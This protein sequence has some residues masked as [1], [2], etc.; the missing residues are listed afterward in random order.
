MP[1]EIDFCFGISDHDYCSQKLARRAIKEH[2]PKD[3][4]PSNHAHLL[5]SLKED[6][7]SSACITDLINF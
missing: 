6:T 3:L 2:Q 4:Q 1:F 7:E 5:I